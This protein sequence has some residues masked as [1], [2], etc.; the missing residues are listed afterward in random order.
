[1]NKRIEH[2]R[3]MPVQA[4]EGGLRFDAY[5]PPDLADWLL[6]LV[7]DGVFADPSEAAF[8]IF[9]EHRD[10]EPHVDL[11][12]ELLRRLCQAALD[13][14]RPGIPHEEMAE[15]LRAMPAA[16]RRE[17]AMWREPP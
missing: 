14:P 1:M 11:R 17:P 3:R 13:D 8:V 15:R 9:G 4:R 7:E 10:L 16:P 12:E 2:V 6:G 5:L